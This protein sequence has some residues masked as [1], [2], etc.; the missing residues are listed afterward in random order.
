MSLSDQEHARSPS[1]DTP[2]PLIC[3]DYVDVRPVDAGS[4]PGADKPSCVL[5]RLTPGL[6][7]EDPHKGATARRGALH[8]GDF[9]G[10]NEAID[11]ATIP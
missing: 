3:R 7:P 2:M 6:S 4:I 5:S 10:D 11:R 1:S 9:V 8:E